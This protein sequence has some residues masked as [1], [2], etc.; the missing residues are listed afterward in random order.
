MKSNCDQI[1]PDHIITYH[2]QSGILSYWKAIIH[3]Y[4]EEL[5]LRKTSQYTANESAYSSN[6]PL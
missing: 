6:S 3:I 5:Y 1:S 4:H 2:I